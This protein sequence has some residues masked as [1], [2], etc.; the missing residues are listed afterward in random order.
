MN[1]ASI[2]CLTIL[3]LSLELFCYSNAE[4]QEEEDP[5]HIFSG[6]AVLF[7]INETTNTAT[8]WL[9]CSQNDC[10]FSKRQETENV[11]TH[12]RKVFHIYGKGRLTTNDPIRYGDEVALFYRMND[13]GDGLWLGCASGQKRCGLGTCPG[14]PHLNHWMWNSKHSCDDN[15]FVVSGSAGLQNSTLSGQPVRI[16]HQ[17][18]LIKKLE[19]PSM[20]FEKG[21]MD[22]HSSELI[23]TPFLDNFGHW[24]INKDMIG[25][26]GNKHYDV[27]YKVCDRCGSEPY[28]RPKHETW[29]CCAGEKPYNTETSLC[30]GG[31]VS[32]LNNS[33]R[34]TK[35]ARCC[36]N[37]AFFPDRQVCCQ[38]KVR[39]LP[40]HDTDADDTT[41]QCC[42]SEPYLTTHGT[43]YNDVVT[44]FY[45]LKTDSNDGGSVCKTVKSC[46]ATLP[47]GCIFH[48]ANDECCPVF[49]CLNSKIH[50]YKL[51][52]RRKSHVSITTAIP[53]MTALTISFWMRTQQDGEGTVLSYATK[54]Q[55]DEIVIKTHPKIRVI[56]KGSFKGDEVD[57]KL[58]DGN[59][60]FLWITWESSTG[61]LSIR[62]GARTIGP[63][64]YTKTLLEGGGYL[65]LGQRQQSQKKFIAAKAF[66][67][68][69]SH[70]NIWNEKRTDFDK[71]RK[72]CIGLN[73]GNVF[74]LSDNTIDT[75]KSASII[76]AD[77]CPNKAFHFTKKGVNDA[78]IISDVKSLTGDFTV[79]LWMNSSD[80]QGSLVSYAVPGH[81]NEVLIDYNNKKFELDIDGES[82][83]TT[84]SIHNGIWQHFCV[85]WKSNS[86]SWKFYKNGDMK[87]EGTD[88]K[89]GHTI[90]Q[91]GTLV[92]GQDQDSVGGGFDATQSFKGMLSSVNIWDNV[93]SPTQIK[94]MST[95][96]LLDEWNAG[97]VYCR[98]FKLNVCV[99]LFLLRYCVTFARE[100]RSFTCQIWLGVMLEHVL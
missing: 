59:W 66:V 89:K 53:E 84:V 57:L 64:A 95:S 48:P 98:N 62:E 68:E 78:V 15:K 51:F 74:E 67:G 6:D 97:N 3:F 81:D 12:A 65:V 61:H 55:A 7:A 63:L 85:T 52:L 17:I 18:T 24:V 19:S 46:P 29:K 8:S 27:R 77:M 34:N 87:Q 100:R 56:L 76:E 73:S 93:L 60:H 38:G 49:H 22:D 20:K 30:C 41:V 35:E 14:L 99:T 88:F 82:R 13:D 16:E 45:P 28:V 26:C 36:S 50:N 72:D 23:E 69:I 25:K 40:G 70:V 83:Q 47:L 86:G 54:I 80:T 11:F 4:Q 96:C 39:D 75:H 9:A 58:N 42:G 37:A 91:G 31:N 21:Y 94:E 90:R 71:I 5:D 1:L 44:P 92:L 32:V 79:C 2:G 10:N 33:H 43:C